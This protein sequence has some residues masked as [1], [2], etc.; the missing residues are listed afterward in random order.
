MTHVIA[1]AIFFAVLLVPSS[2]PGQQSADDRE[3]MQHR[4]TLDLVQRTVAVERDMVAA[5]KKDPGLMKRGPEKTRGIDASA[6]EMNKI[7][8]IKSILAANNI[9]ARD[10]LLTLMAMFSTVITHEFMAS[11]KMPPLP[12]DTPMHNLE[13]WKANAAALKPLEAEW[14][15]HRDEI[16][17]YTK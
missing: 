16:M 7:P 5:L 13:F 8:E 2:A 12:P 6:A 4:L 10:Y 1:A 14:R 11:G 17:K 9:S 15:K 3:I